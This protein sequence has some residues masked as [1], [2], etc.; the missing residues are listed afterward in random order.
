MEMDNAIEVF[1]HRCIEA[2]KDT[3]SPDLE[4]AIGVYCW[5]QEAMDTHGIRVNSIAISGKNEC[6]G[7]WE[8][9][10][11]EGDA[12]DAPMLFYAERYI[13]ARMLENYVDTDNYW[14]LFAPVFKTWAHR[15]L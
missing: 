4:F 14:R 1:K 8:V 13:L 7:K 9:I 3:I 12:M 5:S 2:I 11:V 6:G 15:T 10:L